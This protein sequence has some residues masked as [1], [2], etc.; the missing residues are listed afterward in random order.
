MSSIKENDCGWHGR[1]EEHFLVGALDKDAQV[2][3]QW[4]LLETIKDSWSKVSFWSYPGGHKLS[5]FSWGWAF[6]TVTVSL[7]QRYYKS[8]FLLN[9]LVVSISQNFIVTAWTLQLCVLLWHLGWFISVIFQI[10]LEAFP[11]LMD[12]WFNS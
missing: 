4:V 7:S 11:I 9:H 6:I 10:N 1:T 2:E 5:S 8:S 12:K 3:F